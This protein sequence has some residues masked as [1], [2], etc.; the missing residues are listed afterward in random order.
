MSCNFDNINELLPEELNSSCASMISA[1]Y[2]YQVL[3]SFFELWTLE[4]RTIHSLVLHFSVKHGAAV[5]WQ[6][7]HQTAWGY[8]CAVQSC[9]WY[10]LRKLVDV[11]A[12]PAGQPYKR[13]SKRQQLPTWWVACLILTPCN[14][15][16]ILNL[17]HQKIYGK[18]F[19]RHGPS[20][21]QNGLLNACRL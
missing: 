10:L 6:E 11:Q 17:F 15:I 16:Y 21:G 14:I 13:H 3:T 2:F 9:A 5:V 18:R 7:A 20:K 19:V 8:L 12:W 1:K 4:Q